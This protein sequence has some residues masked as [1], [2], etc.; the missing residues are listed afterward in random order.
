MYFVVDNKNKIIFGWSPKCGCTH[1]KRIYWFLKT[2][3]V[4]AKVHRGNS[5]RNPLPKNIHEY[6]TVLFIRNPYRRL[7]SGFLDKYRKGGQFR[8]RWKSGKLSFRIFV[9]K[10]VNKRCIIIMKDQQLIHWI[11]KE[12]VNQF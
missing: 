6:R 3:N 12:V 11:L 4:N 5:E 9:R 10:L 1:V 8:H 2:G 7:M